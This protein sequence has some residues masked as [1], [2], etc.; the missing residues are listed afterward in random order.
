MVVARD[1]QI[2][3]EPGSELLVESVSDSPVDEG[4]TREEERMT[5][6]EI[7]NTL[8]TLTKNRK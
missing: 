6:D 8:G 3:A 4:L 2:N 5:T 1:V 7:A